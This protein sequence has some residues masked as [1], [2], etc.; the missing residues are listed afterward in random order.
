MSLGECPLLGVKR[1]FLTQAEMSA[2][3]PKRTLS[4]FT[5]MPPGGFQRSPNLLM[6]YSLKLLEGI[7]DREGSGKVK[8][9]C[10]EHLASIGF[11]SRNNLAGN[12]G[13]DRCERPKRN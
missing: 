5:R 2:F 1:T 8:E 4:L 13:T 10:S 11:R 9:W 3:D 6:R 7:A 12:M